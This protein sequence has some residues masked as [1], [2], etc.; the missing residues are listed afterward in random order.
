MRYRPELS[1][2]P[3]DLRG[4][5]FLVV[6]LDTGRAPRRSDAA[7]YASGDSMYLTVRATRSRP[8]ADSLVKD[9]R[10]NG[11]VLEVRPSWSYPSD[12]WRRAD[13][14]FWRK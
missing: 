9:A 12:T 2:D 4:S 3:L 6:S 7:V 14:D 8:T 11:R 10:M 13:P 5:R 1:E